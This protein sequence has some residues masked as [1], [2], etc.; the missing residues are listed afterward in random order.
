M[1]VSTDT[2]LGIGGV[3][4]F[5][6]NSG[7]IDVDREEQRVAPTGT[8]RVVVDANVGLGAFTVHHTEDEGWDGDQ[9]NE[10]CA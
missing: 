8:P 2:H 6:H 5:D 10:A 7:G 9:G 3:Q 1:C 4:V